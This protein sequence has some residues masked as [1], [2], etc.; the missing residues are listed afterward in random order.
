MKNY[1]LA[2]RTAE[3]PMGTQCSISKF[4]R[5]VLSFSLISFTPMTNAENPP[6]INRTTPTITSPAP[7]ADA[8]SD[9]LR[10]PLNLDLLKAV[11]NGI[12]PDSIQPTPIAGLY[13]VSV[14]GQVLYLSEDGRFA[15]QGDLV[16]L[17]SRQNLTEERRGQ[18]RISAIKA[19]GENKMISFSPKSPKHTVTIFTDID[20]GYCRTL[21]QKIAEYLDQGIA[22]NYL[23]YPRSGVGSESYLKA[24]SV[25]CA[26]DRQDA[27][28]RAKSGQVIS[29]KSC[30]NP[31]N[32]H[33]ELGRLLGVRGTPSIILESGQLVPGY[34]TAAQLTHML[35]RSAQ[36]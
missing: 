31:V 8:K 25:W 35:N 14:E 33:L 4:I 12:Q 36:K 5:V 26:D 7:T 1:N 30:D 15:L 10:S 2:K 23:L 6:E 18:S 21:H 20:C 28:T 17:R 32:A 22:I 11:T 16:D 9:T 24:V 29:S 19:L 13:E 3:Y 27:L 34:V